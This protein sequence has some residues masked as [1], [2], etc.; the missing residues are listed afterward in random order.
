MLDQRRT[1]QA[2]CRETALRVLDAETEVTD[3]QIN[4]AAAVFTEMTTVYRA[5]LSVGRLDVD[6]LTDAAAFARSSEATPTMIDLCRQYAN[7]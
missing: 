6:T 3:A 7:L 5:V 2:A 1:L 4:L